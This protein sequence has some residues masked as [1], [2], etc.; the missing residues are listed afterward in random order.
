[1]QNHVHYVAE[2]VIV[3]QFFNGWRVAN[4]P[5]HLDVET[6]EDNADVLLVV[7]DESQNFT[8]FLERT[9]V[10]DLVVNRG[11]AETLLGV[12]EYFLQYS[13]DFVPNFTARVRISLTVG[14]GQ[15]LFHDLV[16]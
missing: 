12:V 15:I 11:V 7:L 13:D 1:M 3:D 2:G 6:A 5:R 9:Q 14:Q 16:N 10:F 8:T 4:N